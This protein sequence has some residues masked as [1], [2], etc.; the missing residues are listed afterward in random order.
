[1]IMEALHVG[2]PR[3]SRDNNIGRRALEAKWKKFKEENG[4]TNDLPSGSEDSQN[5]RLLALDEQLALWKLDN[6]RSGYGWMITTRLV[7]LTRAKNVN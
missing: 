7:V 6:G 1:M 3:I 4:W 2:S 5:T